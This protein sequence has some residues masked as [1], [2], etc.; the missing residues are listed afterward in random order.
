[1]IEIAAYVGSIW[2]KIQSSLFAGFI[3]FAG[4]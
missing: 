1:V 2:Q 4:Q 3:G